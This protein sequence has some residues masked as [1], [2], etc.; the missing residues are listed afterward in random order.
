MLIIVHFKDE[1]VAKIPRI[2][3]FNNWQKFDVDEEFWLKLQR[4]GEHFNSKNDAV[5]K[6]NDKNKTTELQKITLGTIK[7]YTTD[8]NIDEMK[9][10]TTN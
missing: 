10:T 7:P 1:V 2:C 3:H 6:N 9:N 8:S 4:M 5:T